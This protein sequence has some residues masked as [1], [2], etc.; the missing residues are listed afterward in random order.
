M[1]EPRGGAS[2]TD[3]RSRDRLDSWKEI[4]AYLNRDVT[5]VQR[6]EKREG[7][8]VHRHLHDR[9]GS[10]YAF[11]A[12]LDAWARTRKLPASLDAEASSA[13]QAQETGHA[14]WATMRRLSMLVAGLAPVLFLGG[15]VLH[16]T[17]RSDGTERL[18]I[19]VRSFQNMSADTGQDYFV[20]GLTEEVITELGRLNPKRMGVVRYDAKRAPR[21]GSSTVPDLAR[22][23][24]LHYLLEGSV[25]RQETRARISLQLVRLSDQA[26]VWTESV[27]RDV[28]DVLMLQSEIAR[29]IGDELQIQ[30]LGRQSQKLASAQAAEA[31]LRGRFELSRH[32]PVPEAAREHLERAIALDPSYAPSYAGLADYYR[33]CA[34]SGAVSNDEGVAQAWRL[35]EE[36][37][38]RALAIDPENCE[39]HAAL[40][41][42]KLMHDWDWQGAREHALHALQLNPSSPEAHSVYARYLSVAGNVTD[43][44]KHRKQALAL[45]PFRSDL[46][47]Q[48]GREYLFARDFGSAVAL[49]RR[50]LLDNPQDSPS[51]Y[52]LC[53]SLGFMNLFDDA[54]AECSKVLAF[55][56]HTDWIE[57]Y[58]R[59]YGERGYQ[60]A[61]L[62]VARKRLAELEGSPP[63][64]LWELAGAYVAAGRLDE[65]LRT[66]EQGLPIHEPGLLQLR[67]DPD[68][69]SIRNDPRY[70]RII[71][72][73]DFPNEQP[74]G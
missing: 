21:H 66:L 64:D 65:T 71:R 51:H 24:G 11:R 20:D 53:A 70:N 3:T 16:R 33:S 8:P 9:I 48:L 5:T 50:A 13:T 4:A 10:V 58:V 73:I 61:T 19:G 69:D 67:V 35:A 56:G 40:A 27:D 37:A 68:F 74:S 23:L 34:V 59:E 2:P 15:Y 72:Q 18:I 29:R 60:A 46:R 52:G 49:H 32:V 45:D 6:W 42:I 43:A 26:T 39:A 63:S 12:E 17:A 28:G 25:R 44:V 55:E 31:Y 62:L 57:L 7:M 41:Q 22:E 47:L 36:N 38:T 1:D 54:V 14:G 30:V